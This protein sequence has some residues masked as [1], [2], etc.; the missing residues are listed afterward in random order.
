MGGTWRK[1]DIFY[2]CAELK[3]KKLKKR[4]DATL[5]KLKLKKL[6]SLFGTVKK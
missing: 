4:G 6:G 5:G 1:K 3:I 2:F